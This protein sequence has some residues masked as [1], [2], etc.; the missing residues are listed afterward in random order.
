MQ[1]CYRHADRRAGVVCQRCDR[2]ICPD[3]MRQASVGFHCPECTKQGAQKVVR[4]DQLRTRPVATLA[5]I[6]VNLVVFVAGIGEGLRTSARF[7]AEGGLVASAFNPF[8]QEVIGVAHGEWWRIVTAGFLH[9]TVLHVAFNMFI[10]Y[11]L[12]VVLEPAL[13]RWRFLL[14]YFVSML[15]GSLGV[16][17]VD[18]S[19]FT[20]GASG[21]VFGMMG[22]AVAAFR[23]RGINVFDTGL[24]ALLVLN[25]ALTFTIS[26]ISVGGHIGGL[27]AGFVVGT[28]L[29]DLGPRYLKDDVLTTTA[30]VTLGFVLAASAVLVA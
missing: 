10:L 28:I 1:T 7:I 9:A 18:P 17:L 29:A 4:A 23:S 19:A 6:G 16:M 26:G 22:V 24:G 25:L 3:C 14:A 2:P 11:Q 15:G 12:G 5:L 30:V 27:I 21:A 8:T 20:V 13:G